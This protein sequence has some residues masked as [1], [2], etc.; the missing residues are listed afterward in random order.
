MTTIVTFKVSD[1]I[2]LGAD[3]AMTTKKG[4][5]GANRYDSYEKLNQVGRL[6]IV[7]AMWGSALTAGRTVRSLVWEFARERGYFE[8]EGTGLS[9]TVEDVAR[10]LT[11]FILNQMEQDEQCGCKPGKLQ[12]LVSGYS[13]GRF[14]PE[15]W[16]VKLPSGQVTLRQGEDQL[17][18]T[19]DGVNEDIRTLW[20]GAH[21]SLPRILKRHGLP[22][23]QV[24]AVM[25]EVHQQAAW[26]PERVDFSMPVRDAAQL[27]EFLLTVQIMAERFK[28]GP[29]RSAPPI[30]IAVVR[31]D[32]VHWVRRKDPFAIPAP[33]MRP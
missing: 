20:W 10:G 4:R 14:K 18:L 21:P 19:W 6:P 25:R 11:Q 31:Y 28:P 1:G 23:D 8:P 26:G 32:G 24:N 15:Q 2:V 29:A 3:S 5:M 12:L 22:Q 33:T 16:Q 7:T 13:A 27:V 30:D 9:W 17:A